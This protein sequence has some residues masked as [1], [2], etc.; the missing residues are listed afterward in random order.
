M[1]KQ[2]AA[3]GISRVDGSFLYDASATVALPQI[4]A[5]QPEAA[6]YNCGVSALSLNFNRVAPRLADQNGGDRSATATARSATT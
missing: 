2:L 3:G 5:M 1:A 4:D 6:D